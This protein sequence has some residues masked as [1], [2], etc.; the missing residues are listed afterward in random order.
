MG[1]SKYSEEDFFAAALAIIAERGVS[2]MTVAAVSERLGSPTGSFY[3]R[4]ASR[5]ILLGLLW[6]RAVL[7]FQE[8]IVSALDSGDGLRAALH[9]P[10]WA[11]KHPH[12]ARLLLLYDRKDF[13]HG[14]WPRELRERVA[15]MTRRIEAGSRQWARAIFGKDGRDEVRLAQ[16]L[17][18][19]LPV[20]VVRQH[21][22][23]GEPPPQLVDR[24]IRATYGAVLEDYRSGKSRYA[25][26]TQGGIKRGR[27]IGT[28]TKRG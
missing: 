14:E 22:S 8:G 9:T 12:E 4:F 1:R 11:R 27:N 2:E 24:I 13:L 28:P 19:E 7:Q 25:P 16:F 21:L 20:A 10:A 6:L 3:H 23:R 5:N 26:K 17:I 15:E 18:S